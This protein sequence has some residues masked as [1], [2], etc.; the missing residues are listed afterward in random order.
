MFVRYATAFVVFPGGLGTLDELFELA[1]LMQAGKV[2]AVPVVLVRRAYWEPLLGWL[3]STV[4]A[5]G[6]IYPT[7]WSCWRS[8]TTPTR[9]ASS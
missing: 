1:A 5:G 6:K 2:R 3:R 9:S 4:L 7:P 8:R